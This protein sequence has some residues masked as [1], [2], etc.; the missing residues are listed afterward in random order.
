MPKDVPAPTTDD[1]LYVKGNKIVDKYGQEVWITGVNW[2][3]YN[4]G[5]N[6]FDG[7]WAA[8]LNTSLAAIADRGFNLLRIPISSELI[9][10]W[11][12]GNPPKANFNEAINSYL[13]GMDSLQIFDYVV[14]QSGQMV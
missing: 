13:V 14:G 5:T 10:Q 2:F 1:W 11:A 7:L 3:G 12:S 8:D 6:T 9:L 4:T